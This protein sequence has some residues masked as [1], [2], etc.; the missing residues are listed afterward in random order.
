ME[1]FVP[2]YISNKCDSY[3]SM[4]NFNH[5]NKSIHRIEASMEEIENQLKIL[6]D[7]EKIRAV[8]ILT[9]EL[10]LP[11]DRFH[12]IELVC[13]SIN[14]AFEIGFQRVFFNIGS[15]EREEISYIYNHTDHH[16][17]IVLSLF[18]E[19]YDKKYYLQHFGTHPKCNP[20]ANYQNRLDTVDRW[21]AFGFLNV[22]LGILLGFKPVGDDVDELIKHAKKC[23]NLG[24][25]VYISTPRVKNGQLSD[26]QY[27]DILYKIHK[28]LPTAKIIITTRE[29]IEF[30]NN[31]INIISVVSPGCSDI[32][33]Y[34]R[35]NYIANNIA[36]SQF[37][38]EN[39]R[40][41]P[42]DVLSSLN[43]QGNIEYFN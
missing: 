37:V 38:I 41:R 32:C 40:L 33:P 31:V 34:N 5:L 16:D 2:L 1:T 21:L 20:K 22:D 42:F 12:N 6:F 29:K 18:Q 35:G 36:T 7:Y 13:N 9:G 30:I 8:C 17:S 14:K 10:F 4:C 27:L 24:A 15:L 28:R 43:Y 39:K 3:C 26:E 25:N 19:T 11:K 23:I